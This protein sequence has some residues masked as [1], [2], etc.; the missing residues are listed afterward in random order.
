[1]RGTLPPDV[2]AEPAKVAR[3]EELPASVK[4]EFALVELSRGLGAVATRRS[5]R[6]WMAGED[7]GAA[8]P[9]ESDEGATLAG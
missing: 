7:G 4:P 8:E 5:V 3:D 6:G 9:A 2:A 1:M